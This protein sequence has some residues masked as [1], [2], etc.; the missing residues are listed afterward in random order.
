MAK[1][2]QPAVSDEDSGNGPVPRNRIDDDLFSVSGG[3]KRDG[4]WSFQL[5]GSSVSRLL[6]IL[7]AAAT[8]AGA[9]WLTTL[10]GFA[11]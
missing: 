5:S 11:K 2:K 4:R 3:V 10:L 7:L 1:T 9:G 6:K 8:L